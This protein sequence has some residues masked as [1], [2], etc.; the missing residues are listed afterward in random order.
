M[1]TSPLYFSKSNLSKTAIIACVETFTKKFL[2]TKMSL[3]FYQ[4]SLKCPWF[5]LEILLAT[6]L[7]LNM[8][9]FQFKITNHNSCELCMSVCVSQ[10]VNL[11]AVAQTLLHLFRDFFAQHNMLFFPKIFCFFLFFCSKYSVFF[12]FLKKCCLFFV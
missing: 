11:V 8:Y 10:T 12:C 3:N 5:F 7:K 9:C 6:L 4:M 2:M 1:I